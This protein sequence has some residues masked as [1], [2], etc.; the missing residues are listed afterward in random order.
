MPHSAARASA[1]PPAN[2]DPTPPHPPLP[3]S[4][5]PPSLTPHNHFTSARSRGVGGRMPNSPQPLHIFQ[6]DRITH[7]RY[8]QPPP[9]PPPPPLTL[10]YSPQSMSRAFTIYSLLTQTANGSTTSSADSP[11]GSALGSLGLSA[12]DMPTISPQQHH[13]LT[14][15]TPT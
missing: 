12:P 8:P 14:W 6:H 15:S 1:P 3:P 5:H 2:S 4:P 13:T 11:L 10:Q 9:P 7:P